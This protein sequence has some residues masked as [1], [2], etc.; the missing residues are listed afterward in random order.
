M[1]SPGFLSLGF[2]TLDGI[3]VWFWTVVAGCLVMGCICYGPVHLRLCIS[4]SPETW[5]LHIYN[6]SSYR[7]NDAIAALSWK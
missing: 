3:K 5:T 6:S 1:D 2:L 7:T 4:V